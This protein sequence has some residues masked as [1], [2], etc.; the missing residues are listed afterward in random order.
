MHRKLAENK[1]RQNKR[2]KSS[3]TGRKNWA[4][5]SVKQEEQPEQKKKKKTIAVSGVRSEV[6]FTQLIR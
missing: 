4:E 1:L 5:K 2:K 6:L 3:M